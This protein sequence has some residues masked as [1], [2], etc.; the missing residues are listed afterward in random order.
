MIF[1]VD[2]SSRA[3]GWCIVSHDGNVER[4][5]VI[6]PPAKMDAW[7]RTTFMC[8]RIREIVTERPLT[9]LVIEE[10]SGRRL[11]GNPFPYAIAFGRIYQAIFSEFASVTR[12]QASQWTS[13]RDKKSRAERIKQLVPSYTGKGDPGFDEADAIGIALWGHHRQRLEAQA[14]GRVR[15]QDSACR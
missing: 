2:P 6:R 12:V 14:Q 13:C 7:E 4:H 9:Y 8:G 1:G 5:G 3:T 10:P 11:R 15:P